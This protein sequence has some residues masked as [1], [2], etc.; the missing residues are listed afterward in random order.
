MKEEE[1]AARLARAVDDLIQ[2]RLPGDLDD[3]D[4]DELLHIAKIRLDA[5][6]STTHTGAQ[7]EAAVWQQVR[8]R[9]SS[10]R[11]GHNGDPN[12]AAQSMEHA[13]DPAAV[14]D[15]EGL[16]IRELQDV[17]GLRRQMAGQVAC[18]AED[19]RDSVWQQVQ[20][21]VQAHSQ[22]CGLLSFLQR[23]QPEAEFVATAVDQLVLGEPIWEASDSKLE[24]LIHVAR[25]RRAMG[26]AA[27]A[28]SR[29]IQGRLWAR[30]RPRLLARLLGSQK[31][32]SRVFQVGGRPW[33]K[34][35]AIAVA[36][37]A[38]IALAAVGPVPA[39]GLAGHPVAQFV[40]FVGDH[41]GVSET[42]SPP[43]VVPPV[44]SVVQG[45]DVTAAEAAELLGMPV[46]EPTI[47]PSG[48]TPISSKFF[49]EPLTATQ[50][51]LFVRAYSSLDAGTNTVNPPT[52]LIY[53][54]AASGH[55]IVVW[56]AST[57]DF[58]LYDGT[59]ATYIDGSWRPFDTEVIWGEDGAQT[60]VF[61]RAG[62]RTIIHY[63]DGLKM[64]PGY[65]RA[66][67]EGMTAV[68]TP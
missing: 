48:F 31:P 29:D 47:M 40:R 10:S 63:K 57:T 30:I 20:V 49:P 35:A 18:V 3:Q 4:L 5:A 55:D 60:V 56:Q 58:S 41:V 16:D 62:L 14:D 24:E 64:D 26:Q 59:P 21:R 6:R 34:A 27:T 67:A 61:D 9:L 43:P 32:R 50:G 2:G 23:P 39:T 22:K 15:P 11:A 33:P 65:L 25:A 45:T 1:R 13:G 7:H 51:G 36:G 54:E 46:S 8:A 53:Q 66:I 68:A 28:A 12:G 44:T 37:A 38:A 42:G 19:H 52:I 17:I